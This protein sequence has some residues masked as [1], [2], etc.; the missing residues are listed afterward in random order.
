MVKSRA[1]DRDA[2]RQAV[3]APHLD[4]AAQHALQL[5]K[6]LLIVRAARALLLES[7]AAELGRWAACRVPST[8]C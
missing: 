4:H 7:F 2:A 8:I 3:A 5:T 1:A 6:E